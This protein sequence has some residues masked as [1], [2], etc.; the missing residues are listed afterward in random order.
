MFHIRKKSAFNPKY[1][2]DVLRMLTEIYL[3]F[4]NT[5][6]ALRRKTVVKLGSK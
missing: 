1:I 5:H 3:S 6:E 2:N 4:A